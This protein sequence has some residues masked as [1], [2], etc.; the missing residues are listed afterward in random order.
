[1]ESRG[2]AMGAIASGAV[3][4]IKVAVQ[5]LLLPIMARLLGPDEFGL[6]SLALPT[7]SLVALL[8]DGGLGATLARED[9]SS[10]LVW[11]TAFWTLLLM[12]VVLAFGTTILGIV[13]GY[14]SHEPRLAPVMAVLSVSLIFLTLSVIPSARLA[15][16][17]RLGVSATADFVSTI[18]GAVIAVSLATLGAGAWSLA[19]QYV[20]MFV[21]RAAIL[22]IASFQIPSM[23]FDFGVLRPHMVSGGILIGTRVTEYAGRMAENFL[24][25]RIFGT[26][27]LGNYTFANQITKYATD[28]AANVVW[29]ALYVQALT[30]DREKIAVLHRRLCRLL[31]VLLFPTMFLAA[32]AAPEL[33]SFLL[34]PKWA[35]LSIFVRVF[36]PLYSFICSQIAPIL[37]A[38]GRFEVQF[39]SIL[40]LTV[41]RIVA[42]ILGLWFGIEGTVFGIVVVTLLFC[43]AMLIVPVEATGCKPLPMLALLIR[44][45]I[46]S[47][48]ATAACLFFLQHVSPGIVSVLIC[49]MASLVV[50]LL[51]MIV[52]DRKEVME[53]WTMAMKIIRRNNSA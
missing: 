1:M 2:V 52:I 18:I 41:G 4:V 40:G 3:A 46:S 42:V 11:S 48:I 32:A 24:V 21:V 10:V 26:V 47:I 17:K 28:A 27:L 6:Y 19:V 50:Y 49:M 38:Y 30:G 16:Q 51:S 31:A 12:G 45:A 20:A 44:P 25:N 53:D 36:L 35:D 13:L 9:E 8:A 22:N 34:G 33:I 7:V 39:W 23:R 37:L 29:A 5:L 14:L 15:R 43:L